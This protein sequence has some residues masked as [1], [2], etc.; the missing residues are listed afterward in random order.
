MYV[1]E[2]YAEAERIALRMGFHPAFAR[3]AAA[4]GEAVELARARSRAAAR[5]SVQ[6]R[7]RRRRWAPR[8]A[9]T[10]RVRRSAPLGCRP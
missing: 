8:L 3:A 10:L 7:A 1:D 9:W 4:E 2:R 6:A 5:T